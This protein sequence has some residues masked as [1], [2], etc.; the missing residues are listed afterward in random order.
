VPS[1]GGQPTC[2]DGK[3]SIGAIRHGIEGGICCK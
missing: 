1:I 2:P 3:K